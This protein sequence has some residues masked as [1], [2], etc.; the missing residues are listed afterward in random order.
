MFSIGSNRRGTRSRSST[1]S[2]K[3]DSCTF[4]RRAVQRSFHDTM[5]PAP[6]S[7][8]LAA[9]LLAAGADIDY[10]VYVAGHNT[11]MTRSLPDTTP[12]VARLFAS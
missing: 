10:R 12:F 6:L 8:G 11:T 9:D 7:A 2:P 4:L 3:K 5:V 1:T